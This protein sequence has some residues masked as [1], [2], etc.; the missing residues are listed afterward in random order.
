MS[1]IVLVLK[2]V[3]VLIPFIVQLIQEN[4]IKTATEKEVLDAME[5]EFAKR[6]ANRVKAGVDADPSNGGVVPDE[7]HD[8]NNRANKS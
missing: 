4:K 8:P 5:Q 6:W 1:T 7:V 3:L 2:A